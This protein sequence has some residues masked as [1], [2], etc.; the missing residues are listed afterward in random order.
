MARFHQG[1]AKYEMLGERATD[2]KTVPR[3][4]RQTRVQIQPMLR[5]R[6]SALVLKFKKGDYRGKTDL[7][8]TGLGQPIAKRERQAIKNC[9][10]SHGK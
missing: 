4:G 5:S 8:G 2:F 3:R 6:Y 7:S 1:R 9:L 10:W